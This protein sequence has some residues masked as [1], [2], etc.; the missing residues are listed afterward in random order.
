[1]KRSRSKTAIFYAVLVLGLVAI[2]E[3]LAFAGYLIAFHEPIS[4]E[5][6]QS[7][8]LAVIRSAEESHGGGR[9]EGAPWLIHPYY[10]YVSNPSDRQRV[11]KFGFPGH[12]DQIQAAGPDK[13]VIAIIGGSVVAR[14]ASL[15]FDGNIF[16]AELKN[17]PAFRDKRV[18]VLNLGNDAFKQPQGLMVINDILSRG[19]HID[20]LIALDGF[21]EIALPEAHGNLADR[22]SP[23]YPQHWRH[24]VEAR[25]DPDQMILLAKLHYVSDLRV[26]V[27]TNFA[28]PI[29][30]HLVLPNLIWRVAD[31]KLQ[32]MATRYRIM[33]DQQP[34]ANPANRATNDGRAFL[35]PAVEY[36]TRRELY[37]DIARQWGRSSVL[38]NDLIVAQGGRYFHF[39][40]P[41][42]YVPG[43][44][45][46]GDEERKSA[47]HANS[48]Y[49]SPV[50]IGYPYMRAM[51]ASLRRAGLWFED[52]TDLFAANNQTVYVDSCCHF[53][54]AGNAILARAIAAT[55]A[56]R[57]APGEKARAVAFDAVDFGDGLFAAQELRRFV[58]N[59]G[60]YN[61]GSRDL[62]GAAVKSARPDQ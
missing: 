8:R 40:Q 10:G 50:E 24:L 12:E 4:F 32:T 9:A 7:Q 46:F 42:Q 3:L 16:E 54:D 35:G 29:V 38:L 20:V 25:P 52:L 27:A 21:N 48:P 55:I 59:P 62:I 51:G 34:S 36:G 5:L 44:K 18:V 61:D 58:P 14:L 23:F 28:R 2:G 26:S 22:V 43:S 31:D 19:G 17:I 53:N 45:P 47:L 33:I 13:V 49:R 60:D 41:N 6:L 15:A 57:M 56:A 30:R 39:L 11:D 1:M 37:T